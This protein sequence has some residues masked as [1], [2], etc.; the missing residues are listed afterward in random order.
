MN[1]DFIYDSD[2]MRGKKEFDIEQEHYNTIVKHYVLFPRE[3]VYLEADA[4]GNAVFYN[5]DGVELF[6][7]KAEVDYLYFLEFD[8]MAE[9]GKITVSFP[10]LEVVDHYP[11]CDGEY[12]RYSYKRVNNIIIEFDTNK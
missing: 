11:N 8:C 5:L 7:E 12:D 1:Y 6:R 3:G 9:G 4:C 10:V 2:K